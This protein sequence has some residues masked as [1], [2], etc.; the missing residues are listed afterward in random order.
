MIARLRI[1]LRTKSQRFTQ[2]KN[3]VAKK[4]FFQQKQNS[5]KF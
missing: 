3:H 2:T 1:V 5:Q 4:I